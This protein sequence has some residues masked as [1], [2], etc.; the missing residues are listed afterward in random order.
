M[1]ATGPGSAGQGERAADWRQLIRCFKDGA[2]SLQQEAAGHIDDVLKTQTRRLCEELRHIFLELQQLAQS[3]V[4]TEPN[5]TGTW[6][7]YLT[8][9]E[10]A[11]SALEIEVASRNDEGNDDPEQFVE[12]AQGLAGEVRDLLREL[13]ELRERSPRPPPSVAERAEKAADEAKKQADRA[14]AA[15]R[16]AQAAA[17]KLEG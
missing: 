8:C 14:E 11:A 7:E 17:K 10:V 2:D 6:R 16:R 12:D 5:G 4:A 3:Q 1:V 15:A 13:T 9:F